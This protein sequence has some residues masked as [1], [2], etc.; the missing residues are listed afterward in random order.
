MIQSEQMPSLSNVRTPK[1]SIALIHI[2]S[3]TVKSNIQVKKNKLCAVERISSFWE[4]VLLYPLWHLL[5]CSAWSG[6]CE[7]AFLPLPWQ[8][9][10]PLLFLFSSLPHMLGDRSV[11]DV[12]NSWSSIL[13]KELLKCHLLGVV[14]P[15]RRHY[16]IGETYPYHSIGCEEFFCYFFFFFLNS[17]LF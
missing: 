13:D 7:S 4:T 12:W 8:Q 2:S 14:F 3:T 6:T 9:L 17:C 11:K 5:Y 1:C 16:S 10:E 15:Q